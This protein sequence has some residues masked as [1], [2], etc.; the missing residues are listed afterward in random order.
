MTRSSRMD[1]SAAFAVGLSFEYGGEIK[2]SEKIL[3]GAD[4]L[5]V[6]G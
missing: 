4:V 2:W 5:L 3:L 1:R 6:D